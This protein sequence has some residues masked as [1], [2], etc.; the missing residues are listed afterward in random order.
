MFMKRLFV[1]I[2]ALVIIM[3]AGY[4]QNDL[5]K[6][7][8]IKKLP[9]PKKQDVILFNFNWMT[10]LNAPKG[11][12]D[13]LWISP[14][15]RGFDVALMYDIPL[16]RSMFS[17]AT[18]VNFSFENIFTNQFVRD[19][20]GGNSIYFDNINAMINRDN[21]A[22]KRDWQKAKIATAIIELPVE[23]R[24]RLKPHKRNTFK[25]AL[26]FKLGYVIDTWQKYEG[27]NYL[28]GEDLNTNLRQVTYDVPAVSRLRYGVYGRIGYSRF[29]AF[30]HYSISP[31][32]EN[33]SQFAGKTGNVFTIG[34]NFAPF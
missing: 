8:Q 16:G 18:G 29:S 1:A 2:V 26:G 13:S 9:K 15:S 27:P 10:M 12:G 14:F 25:I 4:S 17:F 33:K 20:A 24:F 23:F 6:K 34:F 28:P 32:F 5:T 3:S 31:F 30:V 21:P 7:D 22:T 11:A 19:S